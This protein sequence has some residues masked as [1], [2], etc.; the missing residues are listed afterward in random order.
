MDLYAFFN[1]MK[2]RDDAVCVEREEEAARIR[3]EREEQAACIRAEREEEA[4]R[5]RTKMAE[6]KREDAAR[7]E[8]LLATLTS[9]T[10]LCTLPPRLCLL[11]VSPRLH[12]FRGTCSRRTPLESRQHP[13]L[14]LSR[15][16]YS[17]LISPS[18]ILGSGEDVGWTTPPWLTWPAYRNQNS[19]SN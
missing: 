5:Y 2:A 17:P 8:A 6:Q 11:Q 10:F 9:Q 1:F 7:F 16:Q 15:H 3:A 18:S 13:R 4:A 14:L 12:L 19:S